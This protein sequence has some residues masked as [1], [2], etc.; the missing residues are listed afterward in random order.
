MGKANIA[1]STG[2]SASVCSVTGK[3][4]RTA[5]CRRRPR[6]ASCPGC[7]CGD[8]VGGP[9][10]G[11]AAGGAAVVLGVAGTEAAAAAGLP[12]AAVS[13]GEVGWVTD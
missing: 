7:S 6:V 5:G 10:E 9:A 3:R 13:S 11:A 12:L 1:M 8:V 2:H 4:W